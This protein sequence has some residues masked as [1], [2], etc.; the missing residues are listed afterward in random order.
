MTCRLLVSEEV[1]GM[2]LKSQ[3]SLVYILVPMKPRILVQTSWFVI[4]SNLGN[5]E[6][7]WVGIC[8]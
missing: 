6:I 7:L 2:L 4:L 5:S 3:R 1:N 8:R